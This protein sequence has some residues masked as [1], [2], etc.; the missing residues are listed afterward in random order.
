MFAV[1]E[2][3]SSVMMFPRVLGGFLR[4][5]TDEGSLSNGGKNVIISRATR[6]EREVKCVIHV[7]L[8]HV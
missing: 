6:T 7:V 8:Y 5:E 2:T 3:N 4:E 1:C